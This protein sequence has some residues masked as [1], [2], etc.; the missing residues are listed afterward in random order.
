MLTNW[1]WFR[2]FESLIIVTR[3][4]RLNFPLNFVDPTPLSSYLSF[5]YICIFYCRA[6]KLALIEFIS[7]WEW[8]EPGFWFW[9]KPEP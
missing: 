5:R 2:I 9:S 8:T 1:R 4:K 6:D 7:F 3:D